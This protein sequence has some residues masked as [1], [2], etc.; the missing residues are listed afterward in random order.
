[1][2]VWRELE[3]KIPIPILTRC[4]SPVATQLN[5][6]LM[7]VSVV[8]VLL[9]AAFHFAST[10]LSDAEEIHAILAVSRGV[11]L[12][13]LCSSRIYIDLIGTFCRFLSFCFSVRPLFISAPV[14]N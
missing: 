6:S 3:V 5:S 11:C 9:P 13:L 2:R 10:M 12:F 4:F 8:A 14:K 1:M 7:M